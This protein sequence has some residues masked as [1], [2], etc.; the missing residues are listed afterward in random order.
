LI[1]RGNEYLNEDGENDGIAYIEN[2]LTD[3]DKLLP[4]KDVYNLK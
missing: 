4:M 1:F 3:Y 2:D